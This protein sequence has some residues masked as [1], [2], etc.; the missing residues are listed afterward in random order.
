MT[1]PPFVLAAPGHLAVTGPDG[2]DAELRRLGVRPPCR[3][4][5][6]VALDAST[7]AA[8]VAQIERL[9]AAAVAD[10]FI[11]AVPPERLSHAAEL[12][13]VAM[14]GSDV[15]V[16]LVGAA[17][18]TPLLVSEVLLLATVG[19]PVT[20]PTLLFA[21]T[22]ASAPVTAPPEP[23]SGA[24]YD[25]ELRFWRE[26]LD[27][28]ERWYAGEALKG[29]VKP[30]AAEERT[31]H[32]DLRT[33]AAVTFSRVYQE[34]KYLTDLA[35]HPYAFRGMRVL[36]VGCGPAPSMLAFRGAELHG[37]DPLADGYASVG[38]P[39]KLW[40]TMGFTYHNARAERMPFPDAHF[41]AVV[42]VNAID[43]VDDFA[44]TAQEIRRVLRPGGAFRMH[45]HYHEPTLEEPMELDDDVFLRHYGWV[46]DLRKIGESDTKD[47]GRSRALPGESYVLWG[48][49]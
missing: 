35:L 47:S 31:T 46:Q 6:T 17:D 2:L 12:L 39:L 13:S 5:S 23:G 22:S 16:D 48:N 18:V 40:S 11:I 14:Q 26:T 8:L 49:R 45:V 24:K 15:E 43:H 38:F 10:E 25:A 21:G 36:D 4:V 42:S 29:D 33:N 20:V 27:S 3:I 37:I 41:D 9:A 1:A 32:Y 7:A 30:P 28:W 19:A 44:A 34:P